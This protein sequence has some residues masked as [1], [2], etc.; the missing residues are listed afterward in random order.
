MN[1]GGSRPGAGRPKSYI[2]HLRDSDIPEK[3]IKL[4]TERIE[5]QEIETKELISLLQYFVP[6]LSIQRVE[7]DQDETKEIDI[8]S[9][10]LNKLDAAN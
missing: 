5:S 9:L 1:K 8:T 3:V 10:W 4:L 2:N 7:M 6:R